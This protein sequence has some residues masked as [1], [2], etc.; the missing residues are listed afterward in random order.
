MQ[1][2]SK[3]I[4][5][6]Q[7]QWDE[8]VENYKKFNPEHKKELLN[9]LDKQLKSKMSDD[10]S[11]IEVEKSVKFNEMEFENKDLKKVP[12][13][14]KKQQSC[15]YWAL[16][17]TCYDV[18]PYRSGALRN[19]EDS[20][21][22]LVAGNK[23][24]LLSCVKAKVIQ[25]E[26]ERLSTGS[27]MTIRIRRGP[28]ARFIDSGKCDHTAE[29][30]IFGQIFQLCKKRKE[31]LECFKMNSTDSQM[32]EVQFMGEG[33]QDVGGPFRETLTNLVC[34]LESHA[35]PLLIKTVNNRMDHGF[36]REAWTL[37]PDATSPTH[38][39]LYKF[40]GRFLG[41]NL[42]TGSAMDWHFSPVFWKQLVGDPVSMKDFDGFDQYA[43]TAFRDLEKHAKKYKPEEFDAVVDENFTT[44]LSNQKS[45][46]LCPGGDAKRVTHEN[47]Q[48]FIDL[49]V[50]TRLAEAENQMKWL[51]EGITEVID[52]NILTFLNWDEIEKRA[53]GGDIEVSVLK[54]ISEYRDMSEDSQMGKWFWKMFEAYTQEERK[55]YLKFVWGRSKIPVDVSNL[56][57]KH[58][59]SLY[60][61]WPSNSLPKSHTC[62]F[63]IDIPEYRSYE[64]MVEKITYAIETCG[65]I[66]DDYGEGNI[67]PED[68]DV[69]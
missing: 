34:E 24:T 58:R 28:A 37:N 30:T 7:E 13:K 55:A 16:N 2:N 49:T 63:M 38:Q 21:A 31:L 10:I 43:L 32:W 17:T 60:R 4:K 3:L 29:Y 9:E 56:Y 11:R 15:L 48:E 67:R 23:T 42:R 6:T 50:K 41:F 54:S 18:L 19:L 46:N 47:Y 53:C 57:Y 25:K 26:I 61:H 62:F 64:Q 59:I 69:Y 5:N 68:G 33:S 12:E 65:E 27:R 51:K 52:L 8:V 1:K 36:Y 20:F 40:M 22:Q 45:I 66:D 35:L 14:I 44:I 39:E